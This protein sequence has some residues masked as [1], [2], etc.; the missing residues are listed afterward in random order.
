MWSV[1]LPTSL[2]ELTTQDASDSGD[3]WT[4]SELMAQDASDSGD[5]WTTRGQQ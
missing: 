5:K 1:E 2:A 3:K 4:T